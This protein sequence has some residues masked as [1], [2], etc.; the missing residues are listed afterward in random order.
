MNTNMTLG[1]LLSV[2]VGISMLNMP[3]A[4]A[5]APSNTNNM[6]A[7]STT[8]TQA[9]SATPLNAFAMQDA[10]A[11]VDVV[12]ERSDMAEVGMLAFSDLSKL[13]A[14]VAGSSMDHLDSEAQAEVIA[15]M[16]HVTMDF[17]G[18][19]VSIGSSTSALKT[20]NQVCAVA[21]RMLVLMADWLPDH[22]IT[23]EQLAIQLFF[24]VVSLR[25]SGVCETAR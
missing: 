10:S 14:V 21:G 4:S 11:M 3:T 12:L 13:A 16:S 15:D 24:L 23:P 19:L 2:L 1:T 25:S 20:F 22:S 17:S 8:M 18:F 6:L 7:R 9:K 5:F